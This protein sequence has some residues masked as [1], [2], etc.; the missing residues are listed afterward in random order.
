MSALVFRA[1]WRFM[2][3]TCTCSASTHHPPFSITLVILLLALDRFQ[4]TTLALPE[5]SKEMDPT[6]PQTSDFDSRV[7]PLS[8]CSLASSSLY[9][10]VHFYHNE[11]PTMSLETGSTF[12]FLRSSRCKA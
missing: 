1:V 3:S 5:E 11:V 8:A 2:F 4:K 9:S 10:H 12:W 6:H 7:A